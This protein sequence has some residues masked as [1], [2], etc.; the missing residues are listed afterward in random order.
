MR[1][2]PARLW[3]LTPESQRAGL[4]AGRM[5]LSLASHLQTGVEVPVSQ[6]PGLLSAELREL[7]YGVFVFVTLNPNPDEARAHVLR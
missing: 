6:P 2:R 5:A 1:R 7:G 4:G 3:C